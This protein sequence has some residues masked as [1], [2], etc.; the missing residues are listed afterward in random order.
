MR[1]TTIKAIHEKCLKSIVMIYL[2]VSWES[3]IDFGNNEK[4]NDII[5][6]VSNKHL[7]EQIYNLY[8]VKIIVN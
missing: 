8:E 3:K 2:S 5:V 6:S 7:K 1:S 4:C